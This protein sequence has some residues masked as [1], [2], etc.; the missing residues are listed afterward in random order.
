MQNIAQHHGKLSWSMKR[1]EKAGNALHLPTAAV[2]HGSDPAALPA[3][4]DTLGFCQLLLQFCP[5]LIFLMP[6]A[7]GACTLEHLHMTVPMDVN[8]F[9]KHCGIAQAQSHR[10]L[11]QHRLSSTYAEHRMHFGMQ[12]V[13]VGWSPH[14]Q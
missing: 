10:S 6:H 8:K 9:Q 3:L 11:V 7:A 12:Q 4:D 14:R 1:A 13:A 2:C 5:L